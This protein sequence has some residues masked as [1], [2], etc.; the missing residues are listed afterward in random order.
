[1]SRFET[2]MTSFVLSQLELYVRQITLH[3]LRSE[4]K[5][6]FIGGGGSGLGRITLQKSMM[7]C[8]ACDEIDIMYVQKIVSIYILTSFL[9]TVSEIADS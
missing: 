3:I 5:P 7:P 4:T 9:L 8:S 6:I 1:M 2:F